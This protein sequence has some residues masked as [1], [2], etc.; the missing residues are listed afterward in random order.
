MNTRRQEIAV[1]QVY[2]EHMESYDE[3]KVTEDTIRNYLDKIAD[4][5]RH[6]YFQ[7]PKK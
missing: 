3:P 4:E 2:R 7:V 6:G 5:S 1:K